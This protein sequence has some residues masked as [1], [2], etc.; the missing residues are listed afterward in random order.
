MIKKIALFIGLL[1]TTNLFAQAL[2]IIQLN[3]PYGN[4]RAQLIKSGWT[5]VKQRETCGGWCNNQRNKGFYETLQCA[6]TG[7]APCNFVFANGQGKEIIVI[8]DFENLLFNGF[9]L[10]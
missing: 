1:I 5:P 8:T 2:P 7:T 4:V 10:P 9:R 6:D 3:T